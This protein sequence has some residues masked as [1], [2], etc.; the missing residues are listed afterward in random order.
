MLQMTWLVGVKKTCCLLLTL[1]Y[2]VT[3]EQIPQR[4]LKCEGPFPVTMTQPP[5]PPTPSVT[6]QPCTCTAG[7]NK[8]KN[9]ASCVNK[10]PIT[11]ECPVKEALKRSF[12]R[13]VDERHRD[14]RISEGRSRFVT[15]KDQRSRLELG[16]L[17]PQR[18]PNQYN[19]NNYT[20]AS[21][22]ILV[23]FG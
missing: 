14:I 1:G 19:I 13:Q 4:L 16:L 15:L 23:I 17:Y 21:V 18:C 20:M 2:L 10:I 8:S 11:S 6:A 9:V 12:W 22:C 3:G 5:H 7:K